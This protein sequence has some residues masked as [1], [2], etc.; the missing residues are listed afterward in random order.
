MVLKDTDAR[1]TRK[2]NETNDSAYADSIHVGIELSVH[3]TVFGDNLFMFSDGSVSSGTVQMRK[4]N[5]SL[6]RHGTAEPHDQ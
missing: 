6:R 4:E 2:S 5:R 3:K 1:Y